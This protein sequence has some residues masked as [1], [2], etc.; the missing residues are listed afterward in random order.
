ML[1]SERARVTV[2]EQKISKEKFALEVLNM[3]LLYVKKYFKLHK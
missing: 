3:Y 2:G 1:V